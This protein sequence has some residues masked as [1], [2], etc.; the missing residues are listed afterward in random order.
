M[1]DLIHSTHDLIYYK[2][3]S[4]YSLIQHLQYHP[5]QLP[6]SSTH[7]PQHY[8]LHFLRILLLS[9]S[10][11]FP[12]CTLSPFHESPLSNSPKLCISMS[13]LLTCCCLCCP[14]PFWIQPLF[15]Q[16]DALFLPPINLDLSE[17]FIS[18]CAISASVQLLPKVRPLLDLYV[19][20]CTKNCIS[21]YPRGWFSFLSKIRSLAD[22]IRDLFWFIDLV[23]CVMK[24]SITW[25]VFCPFWGFSFDAGTTYQVLKVLCLCAEIL[26]F[27]FLFQQVFFP[28]D[29]HCWLYWQSFRT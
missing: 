4:S 11:L 12:L 16:V 21:G 10:C 29:E 24:I 20:L 28:I 5:R 3:S 25:N 2:P 7:S 27:Y 18:C 19:L 17:F 23:R 14:H 9:P 1:Y 26:K 8:S 6:Y 13:S 22:L 15:F